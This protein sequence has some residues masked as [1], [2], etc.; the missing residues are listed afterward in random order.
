MMKKSLLFK[1]KLQECQYWDTISVYDNIL[2]T[3]LTVLNCTTGFTS[4]ICDLREQRIHD[5][6]FTGREKVSQQEHESANRAKKKHWTT[7]WHA[8]ILLSKVLNMYMQ[9]HTCTNAP[10]SHISEKTWLGF[11]FSLV[12]GVLVWE[13]VSRW[14]FLMGC[15]GDFPCSSWYWLN[16]CMLTGRKNGISE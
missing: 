7:V 1:Q 9:T 15:H 3:K 11:F 8:N 4:E 6:N 12:I 2:P 16:R 13:V 10:N 5:R 14:L